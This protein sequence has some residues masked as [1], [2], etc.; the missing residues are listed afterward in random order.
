MIVYFTFSATICKL[1]INNDRAFGII[2]SY[3]E[4]NLLK[5]CQPNFLFSLGLYC[6]KGYELVY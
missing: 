1:K 4:E 2:F 6:M 3:E 5:I